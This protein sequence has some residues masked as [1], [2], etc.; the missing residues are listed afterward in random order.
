MS[1]QPLHV[2]HVDS[3]REYRGGQN[4]VRA[5]VA[6]LKGVPNLSQTVVVRRD[7]RLAHETT[8]L[9]IDTRSVRWAGAMDMDAILG[10]VGVLRE[11]WDLVHA[12]DSH[13][14][15]SV[16]VARALVGESAP[17]IAARRVDFPTRRP[18]VWRRADRVI[19]VSRCI[20]SVLIR[21]GIEPSRVEVV[22]SGIDPSDLEPA[23][24]GVLRTAAGVKPERL[25]VAAV[26]ALVPHKDHA[27]FIRAAS[28]VTRSRPDVDFAVFGDGPLL[29]SLE[30][31]VSEVG[32]EHRFRLPGHI[33]EAVRSLG[34]I[35]V[36]VMPSREEGLGTACIEAMLAGRPIVATKAGG[37]GE[38]AGSAFRPVDPG[39]PEALAQE[40]DVLLGA[41]EAREAA[42]LKAEER[43]RV[44]TAAA[45][46]ENTL[47]CYTQIAHRTLSTAF[48]IP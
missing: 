31:L 26:G 40:I 30:A 47:G 10:L 20:R 18:G 28:L 7:S 8:D 27:T 25:F 5:L 6:G 16:L 48:K 34:D 37:L 11:R 24:A 13:S 45:M 33:P 41:A 35:D 15:Q 43:G 39:C 32:L 9:G 44:F 4:Q 14:L 12:H 42:G 2:L 23:R 46:V 29:A 17:L 36:F 38:L 3:A 19:A 1:N 22:Y 21:Q